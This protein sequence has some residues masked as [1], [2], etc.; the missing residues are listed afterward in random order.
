MPRGVPRLIERYR[1]RGGS[2]GECRPSH[3]EVLA[4]LERLAI[5]CGWQSLA[6]L[7]AAVT[8]KLGARP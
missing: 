6:E 2:I 8:L 7:R 5:S 3:A 1:Y 4:A